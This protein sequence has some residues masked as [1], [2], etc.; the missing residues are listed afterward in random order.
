ML[1]AGWYLSGR[2]FRGGIVSAWAVSSTVGGADCGRDVDRDGIEDGCHDNCRLYNPDQKDCQSNGTGDVCDIAY[3][4]SDDLNTNGI[5]DECE[6][7]NDDCENATNM[8]CATSL[9][10]AI[11]AASTYGALNCVWANTRERVVVL[12]HR[13]RS[14]DDDRHSRFGY[15]HR[16]GCIPRHVC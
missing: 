6:P 4:I 13:H 3:G 2:G 15:R 5:P 9:P 11:M 7:A 12:V 10:A 14:H 16:D 8:C 1:P